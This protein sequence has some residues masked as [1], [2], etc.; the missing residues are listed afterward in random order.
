MPYCPPPPSGLLLL[1]LVSELS[2]R[3]PA[4]AQSRAR[5]DHGLS[6]TVSIEDIQEVRLGHRT[7]GLEKF[8]RDVPEDRCFSIIF[9][10]QRSPLDLIAPSPA[11]AQHWVQGLRKIIHHSG[12]MDQRQKLR[13]YPSR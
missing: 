1:H 8:A 12:S 9:K 10:D 6:P 3:A 11:D 7:E 4:S 13:Q 2:A 5:C